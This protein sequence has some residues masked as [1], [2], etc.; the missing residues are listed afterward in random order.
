MSTI[1]NLKCEREKSRKLR[2]KQRKKYSIKLRKQYHNKRI[3][4][5]QEY[6]CYIHCPCISP[7]DCS[8]GWIKIGLVTLIVGVNKNK[9]TNIIF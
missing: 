6:D 3:N 9:I 8:C 7:V 1:R 4:N 2:C 5:C